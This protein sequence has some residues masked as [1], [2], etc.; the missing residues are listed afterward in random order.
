MGLASIDKLE[1]GN[2]KC[3]ASH[4]ITQDFSLNLLPLGL[5][6]FFFATF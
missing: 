5:C 3:L 4:V 1:A 2:E 6:P